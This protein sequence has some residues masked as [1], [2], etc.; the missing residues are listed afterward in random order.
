MLQPQI[1]DKPPLSVAGL[2]TTFI[3]ALSPAAS[4]VEV[5]GPLWE[6]LIPRVNEIERRVGGE[7]YGVIYAR[8]AAERAHCDE[9]VYVAGVAVSDAGK[10]PDGMTSRTVP[11]GRFAVFVHRGPIQGIRETVSEIYRVW[12]PQS[13]Y[14]HAG[15]ADVELYD[16][17]FCLDS[18]DSE[19]E[20]WV[21]VRPK[22]KPA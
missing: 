17:R 11:S 22:A 5:I 6:R 20:Y 10:L 3:H 9:L 1:V 21:S 8:P 4:N 7:M 18:P 14:E 16:H 2:E 12:L 13:G 15:I 19:M